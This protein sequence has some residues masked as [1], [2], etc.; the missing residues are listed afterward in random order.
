RKLE[1]GDRERLVHTVRGIGY[2][3]RSGKST[4]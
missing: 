2:V 4:T 1:E 3:V